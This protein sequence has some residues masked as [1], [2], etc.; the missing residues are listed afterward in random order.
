MVIL[1]EPDMR[2]RAIKLTLDLVKSLFNSISEYHTGKQDFSKMYYIR[3]VAFHK[4]I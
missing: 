4:N 1:G 2:I 3:T